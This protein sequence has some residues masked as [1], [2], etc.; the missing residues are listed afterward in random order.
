[1]VDSLKLPSSKKS[2]FKIASCTCHVP[3]LEKI[4]NAIN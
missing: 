4:H 3:L 2:T 1:M